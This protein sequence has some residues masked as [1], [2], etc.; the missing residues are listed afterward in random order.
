MFWIMSRTEL[1]LPTP[2]DAGTSSFCSAVESLTTEVSSPDFRSTPTIDQGRGFGRGFGFGGQTGSFVPVVRGFGS[3]DV[4]AE[5]PDE[6]FDA[7][8]PTMEPLSS[9][10]PDSANLVVAGIDAGLASVV[11]DVLKVFKIVFFSFVT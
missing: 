3:G 4:P 7:R 11:G 5:R 1:F 6:N 2:A 8:R 10:L 9:S